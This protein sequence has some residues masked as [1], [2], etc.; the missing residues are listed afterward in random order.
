MKYY[1]YNIRIF[2]QCL[3]FISFYGCESDQKFDKQT[4]IFSKYLRE[5]YYIGIQQEEHRYFIV[6]NNSCPAC[7]EFLLSG[8]ET[9]IH[10]VKQKNSII[11]SN[12]SLVPDTLTKCFNYYEDKMSNIDYLNLNIYNLTIIVTSNYKIT[13]IVHFNAND[14]GKLIKFLAVQNN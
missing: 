9:K 3:V 10:F 1:Q 6:T 14:K 2:I 13:D 11:T 7:L 4:K 12:P 5:N 8:I